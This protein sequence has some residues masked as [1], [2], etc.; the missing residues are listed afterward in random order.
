MIYKKIQND[1]ELKKA[2]KNEEIYL[3]LNHFVIEKRGA[4]RYNTQL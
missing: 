2:Q 4:L 1:Y 3:F